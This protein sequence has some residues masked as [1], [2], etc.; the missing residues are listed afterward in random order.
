M[1]GKSSKVK[2]TWCIE[3]G[4]GKFVFF[5]VFCIV[6]SILLTSYFERGCKFLVPYFLTG[7]LMWVLLAVHRKPVAD[8]SKKEST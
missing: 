8:D 4:L 1:K 7:G 3:M 6:L 5:F 2:Y